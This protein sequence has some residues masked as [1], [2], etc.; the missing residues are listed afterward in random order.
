MK[1]LINKRSLHLLA[2]LLSSAGL[3]A[4]LDYTGEP[5]TEDFSFLFEDPLNEGY[6]NWSGDFG[7]AFPWIQNVTL[8]GWY[9]TF[10]SLDTE[11]APNPYT[12]DIS[13][14]NVGGGQYSDALTL[15]GF[16][17]DYDTSSGGSMVPYWTGPG[18]YGCSLIMGIVNKTGATI[19]SFNLAYN[20]FVYRNTG[21]DNRQDAIFVKFK[22]GGEYYDHLEVDGLTDIPELE[23][24]SVLVP[25]GPDLFYPGSEYQ[26]V[27]LGNNIDLG[28]LPTTYSAE[29]VMVDW[30]ADSIL[31]IHFWFPD[32]PGDLL[33][34]IDNVVF[35]AG[36]SGG[37]TWNG[38][39]V[40]EQG[41]VDTGDWLHFVNV[42]HDPWIWVLNLNKYV[43]LGDDSGWVYIP[44]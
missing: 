10:I 31:W 44:N 38:F 27:T 41:W 43:Y 37:N 28:V 17:F 16:L 40:D 11:G 24:Q 7:T 25:P 15:N 30:P 34:G 19:T 8:P 21:P 3:F 6:A 4:T 32:V 13:S 33:T 2:G 42:T 1:T 26:Y 5:L 39:P 12:E 35:S 29:S 20:P 9:A 23:Y 36:T 14:F 18:A 22:V